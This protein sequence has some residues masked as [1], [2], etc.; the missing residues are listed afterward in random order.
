MIWVGIGLACLVLLALLVKV[1]TISW[2]LNDALYVHPLSWLLF[3][4]TL[5]LSVVSLVVYENNESSGCALAVITAII[6]LVWVWW[7]IAQGPLMYAD[8]FRH[9][10]YL[11]S[12][13]IEQS[14]IRDVAYTVAKTNFDSQNPYSKSAPGDLDFI[15]GR[16]ISSI[17][18]LGLNVFSLPTQG[19]FVYDPDGQDKVVQVLETFPFSE[20]GWFSNSAT[21]YVRNVSYFTSFN[22]VVYKELPDGNGYIAVTSL[23]KRA[24]FTR[25]P[26]LWKVLIVYPDGRFELL[27]PIKAE[28]DPRLQGV[29]LRSEWLTKAQTLAYG[30]RYGAWKGFVN[31]MGRIAIQSS[32]VNDENTAPFLMETP[33]GNMWYAPFSPLGSGSMIGMAMALSHEASSPI[34]IWNLP[35]NQAIFAA[36]SLASEIEASPNHQSINWYRVSSESAC[37]NVTILELVPL[38]RKE[39]DGISHLYFMGYVAPA[40][41]STQ[42]MFYS[43][44]DPV[45]RTVYQDLREAD[46]VDAWLRGEFELTPQTVGSTPTVTIEQ[47]GSCELNTL[48]AENLLEELR[49]R[50]DK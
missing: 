48:P 7:L 33:Y 26:Y 47:A 5:V 29:A 31:R 1:P 14:R 4:A 41:K 19:I 15:D 50:L 25:W 44:I 21:Y 24:G 37:G 3:T 2:L 11:E 45:N 8:L 12:G 30:Y 39:A 10:S 32:Q 27:D 16:W 34:G 17:D 46:E 22:E 43:I 35:E 49:R 36:D 18:P 28:D 13:L 38:V 20:K 6:G 9:T 40:P 42:V 23:I